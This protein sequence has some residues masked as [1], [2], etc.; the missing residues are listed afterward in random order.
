MPSRCPIWEIQL[1]RRVGRSSPARSGPRVLWDRTPAACGIAT[2]VPKSS[3]PST[4][5]I[6]PELLSMKV[7]SIGS[8]GLALRVGGLHNFRT[9]LEATARSP[10]HEPDT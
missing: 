9:G 3:L 10:D 4:L 6:L 5:R 7:R 8:G 1:P 2:T